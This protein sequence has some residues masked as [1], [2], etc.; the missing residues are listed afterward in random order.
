MLMVMNTDDYDNDG[1]DDD[2]D[3]D[4]DGDDDDTD[5]DLMSFV[6]LKINKI[7]LNSHVFSISRGPHMKCVDEWVAMWLNYVFKQTICTTT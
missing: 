5:A 1:D 3:D 4:N 7:N 6:R 2:D